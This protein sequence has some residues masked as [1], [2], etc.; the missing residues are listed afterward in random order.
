MATPEADSKETRNPKTHLSQQSKPEKSK[1]RTIY[2][3]SPAVSLKPILPYPK[4]RRETDDEISSNSSGESHEPTVSDSVKLHQAFKDMKIRIRLHGS[5]LP[6][7]YT[8]SI[9]LLTTNNRHE[10]PKKPVRKRQRKDPEMRSLERHT[11]PQTSDTKRQPLE[12]IKASPNPVDS[13]KTAYEREIEEQ[14]NE[15]VRL[16]NAYPGATNSINSIHQRKWYLS[17]DRYASGFVPWT[18]DD[19][20]REWV[21]RKEGD[22]LLG[23]EPFFVRGRD[24]ERSIVTGRTADKVMQDE[25]VREFTGRKGWRPVLE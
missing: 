6:P 12:N 18:Q 5:R 25:G 19:G 23:F 3:T 2:P 16:T 11:T 20:A 14:E 24:H 7:D 17:M 1:Y 4:D 13:N 8:L 22:R 21:R 9:R 10:Q 15:N